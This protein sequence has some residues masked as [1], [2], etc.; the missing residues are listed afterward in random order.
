[1]SVAT[2]PAAPGLEAGIARLLTVGTLVSVVLLAIGG[3]L[4]L[5]S[6]ATPLQPPPVFD[7]SHILADITGLRPT[8]FIWLGLLGTLATPAG[9]V[10]AALIGFARGG[11]RRMAVVA[12]LILI[13]IAAGVVAGTAGA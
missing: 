6:G 2:R 3:I 12:I 9:R 13:V 10:I 7:L 11:E 8:G 5:A 1:M 4:A